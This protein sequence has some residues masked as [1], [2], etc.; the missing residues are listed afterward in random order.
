MN[1]ERALL[2]GYYTNMG[3]IIVDCLGIQFYVLYNVLG[4]SGVQLK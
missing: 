2:F 1:Y 4:L 3:D